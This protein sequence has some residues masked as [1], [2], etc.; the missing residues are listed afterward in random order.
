MKGAQFVNE[1]LKVDSQHRISG[2]TDD[3]YKLDELNFESDWDYSLP[4]LTQSTMSYRPIYINNLHKFK[5]DLYKSH[6]L[7]MGVNL[8]NLLIAGGTVGDYLIN[9]GRNTNDIDIFIYGLSKKQATK[10]IVQ[11]IVDICKNYIRSRNDLEIQRLFDYIENRKNAEKTKSR[12]YSK[13][14][15]GKPLKKDIEV[16]VGFDNFVISY[17]GD[18]EEY[19]KIKSFNKIPI[20]FLRNERT[21]TFTIND[22]TFQLIFRLY[23]SISEILHGFDIGSSA[24][25]FDGNHIYFTSL[26]KF[27]YEYKCNIIDTTRRSTTY[28]NRLVKYFKLGFNIIFPHLDIS[29]I[30]HSYFKYRL[31]EVCELEYFPFSYDSISGN[32]IVSNNKFFILSNVKSDYGFEALTDPYRIFYINLKKF[33]SGN[34]D[35]FHILGSEEEELDLDQIND[36]FSI[37]PHISIRMIQTFMDTIR[38]DLY[39]DSKFNYKYAQNYINVVTIDELL[40]NL[41]DPDTSYDEKQ[42]YLDTVCKKQREYAIN[43]FKEIDNHDWT[44]IKWITDNPGTQLTS[45]F[46]PIIK[47]PKDWYGNYYI[48]TPSAPTFSQFVQ[49]K[50]TTDPLSKPEPNINAEVYSDESESELSS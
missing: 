12:F 47:D 44:K 42:K 36:I 45:S 16:M 13:Y 4:T 41:F 14:N 50:L 18:L 9:S 20:K 37:R 21:V 8:D 10:R 30:R 27:S 40:S 24:V 23:K 29:K 17:S 26:S 25:G 39:T 33:L 5:K 19:E 7:L 49:V 32:R 31:P 28:E 38:S 1:I 2:V 46:N 34:M 11:F 22:S 15:R 6:P 43:K 3:I 35:L 48:K